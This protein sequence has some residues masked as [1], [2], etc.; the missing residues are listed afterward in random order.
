MMR[1]AVLDTT[2]PLYGRAHIILK[3]GPLSPGWIANAFPIT[4]FESVK[5]YAVFGGVPRYW[6]LARN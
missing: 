5:A 1:G 4:A 2:A 3:I 6:E